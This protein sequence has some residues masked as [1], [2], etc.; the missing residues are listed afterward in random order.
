[1]GIDPSHAAEARTDL[2]VGDVFLVLYPTWPDHYQAVG[3]KSRVSMI[4][5]EVKQS[6]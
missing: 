2:F 4:K 6:K 1:M 3:D 5:I